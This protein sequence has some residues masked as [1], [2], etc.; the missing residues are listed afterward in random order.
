[1]PILSQ[2]AAS[3]AKVS[4]TSVT[5]N[6]GATI[7]A[8]QPIYEDPA[9]LLLKPAKS[10]TVDTANVRGIALNSASVGQP[11]TY[12]MS[13][14][15]VT[16]GGTVVAGRAYFLSSSTGAICQESDLVAGDFPTFLGFATSTTLL[17]LNIVAGTVAKA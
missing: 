9:D 12:L 8:G 16:I 10:L 7:A 14:G 3:V 1:M 17:S 13:G 4:G 6:A 11:V 15:T 2:S 5:K